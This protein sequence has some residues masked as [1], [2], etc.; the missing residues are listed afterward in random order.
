MSPRISALYPSPAPLTAPDPRDTTAPCQTRPFI[1]RRLR[2]RPRSSS[3]DRVGDWGHGITPGEG[4]I[5]YDTRFFVAAAGAEQVA[6]PDGLEMVAALWISPDGALARH[7]AGALVLPLP[8]QRILASLAEHGDVDAILAAAGGRDIRSIR[9]R[10]V[11]DARG[12][13][14]LLPEDPDW[15]S[16]P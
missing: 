6:E 12:E 2:S 13:R 3:R 10:I 14:V 8:T 16:D 4:P 1:P 15:F 7:Q 11:R 9:P 5:R